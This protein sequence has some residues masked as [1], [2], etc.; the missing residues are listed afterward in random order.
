MSRVRWRT[1]AT[2]ASSDSSLS[3]GVRPRDAAA[4]GSAL[5]GWQLGPG[6]YQALGATAC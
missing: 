6:E 1:R 3:G 5:L 2:A 4:F